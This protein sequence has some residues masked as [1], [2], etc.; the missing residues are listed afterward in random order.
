MPALSTAL[1]NRLIIFSSGSSSATSIC[2]LKKCNTFAF[3]SEGHATDVR[4]R[5]SSL[6]IFVRGNRLATS[7]VQPFDFVLGNCGD[8]RET[9]L[10]CRDGGGDFAG[11]RENRKLETTVT[12]TAT[13]MIVDHIAHALLPT[14]FFPNYYYYYFSPTSGFAT[15][16]RT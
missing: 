14:L 12:V 10:A 8:D 5:S 15:L 6:E 16:L 7:G 11:R 4:L 9:T 3:A 13:A 2:T 1:L